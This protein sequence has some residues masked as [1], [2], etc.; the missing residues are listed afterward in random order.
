MK[1]ITKKKIT[2][3]FFFF[4]IFKALS[5]YHK[6][7]EPRTTAIVNR[8]KIMGT[9]E[10]TSNPILIYIR[11]KAFGYLLNSGKTNNL[12]SKMWKVDEEYI[13]NLFK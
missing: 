10:L 3:N 7:R 9:L 13:N 11:N 5:E 6:I 8:A 2:G 1:S 4:N 12:L